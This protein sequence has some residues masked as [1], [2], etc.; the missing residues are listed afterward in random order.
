MSDT[1]LR[2][3]LEDIV[4][5]ANVTADPNSLKA[6][7]KDCYWFSPVLKSELEEM[8]ADFIVRPETVDE[9]KAIVA[10]AVAEGIPIT[11]R[12]A[13]TGNY[14]QGIPLHGGIMINTKRMNK[15][16]EI[17][18]D[19]ARV[20]AGVI[21]LSVETQAWKHGAEMRFFPSTMPTSTA[22]GFVAGGSGGIGSIE[23][24]MLFD[25]G[26]VLAAKVV[27]IEAE[28][29]ELELTTWQE[30]TDV[31]HNCGLTA[32]LTEVT[33]ALAPK[34]EW[35]QYVVSYPDIV[36][37]LKGAE[38]F[39]YDPD[40]KK[41]LVTAFEW[42][43]PSFFTPL[44]KRGACP[45]GKAVVFLYLAAPPETAAAWFAETGGEQTLH[46]APYSRPR[47]GLE[48]Y[49]FTWNHT[50]MWAIKADPSLTYLQDQFER[51]RVYEQLEARKARFG[52]QVLLHAEFSKARGEVRPGALSIVRYESREQLYEII[53]FCESIGI[54]VANPHTHFLDDDVRWAGDHLLAARDRWDPHGLLNPG[55]L[56][57]LEGAPAAATGS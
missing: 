13:G 45:E 55:H 29:R 27:T 8:A 16:L 3:A 12:G 4:G 43:I 1:R 46:I 32:F 48:L 31:I 44:V 54:R 5:A 26:N 20:E 37:A 33:F 35:H 11:P 22:A 41:R 38:T 50:T 52:D 23:W 15:I 36:S 30:L 7:S 14:G 40:I 17:D 10:L 21:L 9:L 49:D 18:A 51:G 42:P 47:G 19:K 28:P 39:A 2:T 34:T 6:G 25:E 57:A 24:G 53:E 56:R